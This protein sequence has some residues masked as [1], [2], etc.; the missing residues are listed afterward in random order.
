MQLCRMG[1]SAGPVCKSW[2]YTAFMFDRLKIRR[3]AGEALILHH[4]ICSITLR[5]PKALT[6]ISCNTQ[7]A[8]MSHVQVY[9]SLPTLEDLQGRKLAELRPLLSHLDHLIPKKFQSQSRVKIITSYA[10]IP[11]LRIFITFSAS[12]PK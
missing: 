4:R 7:I 2:L 10:A 3:D 9:L 5:D 11:F 8:L 6:L 1:Q 12:W